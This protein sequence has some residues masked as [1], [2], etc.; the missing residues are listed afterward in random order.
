LARLL[1]TLP[2]E[3]CDAWLKVGCIEGGLASSD[4]EEHITSTTRLFLAAAKPKAKPS[5][6][7]STATVRTVKQRA[8]TGRAGET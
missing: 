1:L 8:E 4:E 6:S 7:K 3:D 2:H 5:Q